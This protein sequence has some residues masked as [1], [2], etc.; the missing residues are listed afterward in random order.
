MISISNR[1]LEH[2]GWVATH[3][4]ITERRL[5]DQERD[6]LAAQEQRRI[7]IDAAISAFRKRIE[8]MLKTVA[9]SA[10]A[11][12]ATASTLF[13]SSTKTSERAE[14]AVRTSNK[15][16]ANVQSAASATNE[17]SSSIEEISR[18][19]DQTNS[20]VRVAVTEA[21][22]TNDQ[23]ESLARTAQTIGDVVKLIHNVAGKT[24]LLALNA[25]IEAARAGEAGRGIRG[26]GI[27]SEVACRAN[28]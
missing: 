10:I 22:A 23:I 18:Q 13:A 4:D 20:L 16:S 24:N 25:T 12:R 11:M 6:R 8:T 9:D 26:G 19:L 21:D 17:L 5:Q 7:V 14:T 28:R 3:E 15:A 27:G 1:P 2:G